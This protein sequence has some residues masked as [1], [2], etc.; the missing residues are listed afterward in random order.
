MK[1]VN[2][3]QRLIEK[4]NR[5]RNNTAGIYSQSVVTST[6]LCHFKTNE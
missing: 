3:K 5:E 2:L 6:F 1:K 4:Q